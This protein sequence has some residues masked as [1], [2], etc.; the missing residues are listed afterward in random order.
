MEDWYSVSR[1]EVRGRG[2]RGLFRHHSSLG[3]AL[4]VAYPEFPWRLEG[5][6]EVRTPPRYWQDKKRLMGWIDKAE[7]L[8]GIKKVAALLL[9]SIDLIV[10]SKIEDWYSVAMTDLREL[11]VS[12]RVSR[13]TLVELLSE[14]YPDFRWDKVYMLRGKYAE[15]KRLERMVAS[16]FP[17][18]C[19]CHASVLPCRP[20]MTFNQGRGD[21]NKR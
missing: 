14:K 8:L 5:F 3:D 6:A 16:L 11:G 21:T 10:K 7:E 19:C 12:A 20:Y 17:V 2:G 15:Q 18:M 4:K 1:D 9:S 13:M